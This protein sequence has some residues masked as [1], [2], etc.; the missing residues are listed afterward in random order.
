M[1]QRITALGMV[2]L[3]ALSMTTLPA[4]AA[5]QSWKDAYSKVILEQA[6]EWWSNGVYVNVCLVDLTHDGTTELLLG[7]QGFGANGG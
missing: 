4:F 6:E 1:K 3:L 7:D 5:G 2:R